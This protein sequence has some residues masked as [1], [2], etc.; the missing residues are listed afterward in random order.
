ML[1]HYLL[2]LSSSLVNLQEVSLSPKPGPAA[3][4][5]GQ[6]E[7]PEAARA[8]HGTFCLNF[9]P[10][11]R[12]THDL[13]LWDQTL[14]DKAHYFFPLGLSKALNFVTSSNQ[15]C[16]IKASSIIQVSRWNDYS[17]ILTR[18]VVNIVSG[19]RKIKSGVMLTPR[20]ALQKKETSHLG[21]LISF[22]F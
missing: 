12:S 13:P 21:S 5:Q 20:K 17:S 18:N 22:S 14:S 16:Q 6:Q 1:P 8:G 11:A 4:P 15:S 9:N 3:E 7:S 19:R 10:P 2:S